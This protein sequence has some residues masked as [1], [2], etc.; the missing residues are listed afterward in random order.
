VFDF[1]DPEQTR[2]L[3]EDQLKHYKF[4]ELEDE[5]VLG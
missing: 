4:Q 5:N 3:A 2:T 1:W